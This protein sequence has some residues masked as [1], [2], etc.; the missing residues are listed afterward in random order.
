MKKVING[1]MYN[2][3]TAVSLGEWSNGR[4][5]RD[6]RGVE[7]TLYRKRSGEY[8]IGGWGGSMTEYARP[9]YGGGT[10]GGEK[11]FPLTYEA[12]REWA[13]K[14]LSVDEYEAAFGPVSED[15]ED[16]VI[17]VRV[18]AAAKAALDREVSRTGRTVREVVSAAL[19]ALE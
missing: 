9:A 1:R 12:A 14:H 4:G 3:E 10:C 6:F 8:F 17:S 11:I 19:E 18:S 5:R 7:E 16:I 13:E 15:A 2:T